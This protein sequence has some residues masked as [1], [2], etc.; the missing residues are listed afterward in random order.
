MGL[1]QLVEQLVDLLLT[2][3]EAVRLLAAEGPQA[4]IGATGH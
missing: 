2:T 3:E 4:G 1:G